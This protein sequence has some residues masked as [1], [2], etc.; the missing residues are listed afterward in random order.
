M[1]NV[2][3]ERGKLKIRR[4]RVS[5]QYD[6]EERQPEQRDKEQQQKTITRD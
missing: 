5:P 1:L 4:K 6:A 2:M 3:R